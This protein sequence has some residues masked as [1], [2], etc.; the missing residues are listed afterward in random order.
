MNAPESH[1]ASTFNIGGLKTRK[2]QSLIAFFPLIL[3]FS[4]TFVAGETLQVIENEEKILVQVGEITFLEY[5]KVEKEPPAGAS[6]FYRRSGFIGEVRNQRG[7]L[8]TDT[9][10]SDHIH[11]LGFWHPFTDTL[12][13]GKRIDFWNLK[14]GQGTM[15]FK[16]VDSISKSG[17]S[18][19]QEHVVLTKSAGNVVI[20]E[21]LKISVAERAEP[22]QFD[23]EYEQSPRVAI[24]LPVY[25]YGGGL[26]Y[27]GRRDWTQGKVTVLTSEGKNRT[28]AHA[29]RSRW[30][31]VSGK[32]DFGKDTA[33]VVMNHPTNH[34]SPQRMRIHPDEPFF[35]FVPQQET[36]WKLEPGNKYGMKYRVLIYPRIPTVDEIEREWKIYLT[37]ETKPLNNCN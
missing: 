13:E 11:H 24:D 7:C 27:R 15:R 8:V 33:V 6:E 10:P 5:Y 12:I 31:S 34:D 18:V 21:I 17:F 32:D 9:H 20:D 2:N 22:F 4:I 16:A 25:R 23:Y 26:A 35:N 28:D 36:K 14:K 29:T 19:L 1:H 3:A 37:A 30:F